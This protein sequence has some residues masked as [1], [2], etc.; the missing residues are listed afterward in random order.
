MKIGFIGLGKV[1]SQLAGDG[2]REGGW[3]SGASN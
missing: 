3:A 2:H 1:D